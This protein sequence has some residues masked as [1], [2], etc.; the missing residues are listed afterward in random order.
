MLQNL[1]TSQANAPPIPDP[2]EL[3][4]AA[5][6]T[7]AVTAWQMSE[8]EHPLIAPASPPELLQLTSSETHP[9]QVLLQDWLKL[10]AEQAQSLS[11]QIQ[12][13]L[14]LLYWME[15]GA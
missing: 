7:P 4:S 10:K 9:V 11:I 5:A 14:G 3:A 15:E 2:W 13:L 1:S 6:K 8:E 12:E